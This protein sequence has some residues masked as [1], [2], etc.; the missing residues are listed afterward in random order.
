MRLF[1]FII[2]KPIHEFACCLECQMFESI[3]RFA[4]CLELQTKPIHGFGFSLEDSF[5]QRITNPSIHV[6][7]SLVFF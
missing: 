3:H 4:F 7:G 2:T 5:V 6:K 1:L